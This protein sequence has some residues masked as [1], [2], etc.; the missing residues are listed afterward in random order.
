[1]KIQR[2]ICSSGK[3]KCQMGNPTPALNQPNRS[4]KCNSHISTS[5]FTIKTENVADLNL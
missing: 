2:H 3:K 5:V 1:M 4:I